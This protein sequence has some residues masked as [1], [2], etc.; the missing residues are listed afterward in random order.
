MTRPDIE[1]RD[2]YEG[3]RQAAARSG[4]DILAQRSPDQIDLVRGKYRGFVRLQSAAQTSSCVASS[5]QT[6]A[7]CHDLIVVFENVDD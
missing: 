4:W 6:P 3:I 1:Q 7:L 5:P 2:W